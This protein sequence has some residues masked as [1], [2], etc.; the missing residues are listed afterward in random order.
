MISRFNQLARVTGADVCFD[1]LL[2]SLPE[3]VALNKF[4]AS[5][6]SWVVEIVVTDLEKLFDI[7]F[8]N[9]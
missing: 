4:K 6:D 9:N 5:F 3:I 2:H 8:R 7:S 1:I